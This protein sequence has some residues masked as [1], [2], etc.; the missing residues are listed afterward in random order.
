MSKPIIVGISGGVDSS[1][2][3]FALNEKWYDIFINSSEYIFANGVYKFMLEN[4]NK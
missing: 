4:F 2:S 1:V 3:A